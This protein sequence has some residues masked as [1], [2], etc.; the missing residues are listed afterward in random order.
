MPQG[1]TG[2]YSTGGLEPLAEVEGA[3]LVVE[4]L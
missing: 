2:V 4:V 3:L 1:H